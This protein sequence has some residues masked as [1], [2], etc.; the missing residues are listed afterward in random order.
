MYVEQGD[1]LNKHV[2]SRL[3]KCCHIRHMKLT[4]TKECEETK[5]GQIMLD[6]YKYLHICALFTNPLQRDMFIN[7]GVGAGK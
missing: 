1:F 7:Y 5:A 6:V 2:F 3:A 4:H